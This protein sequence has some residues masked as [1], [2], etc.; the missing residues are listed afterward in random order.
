MKINE[1]KKIDTTISFKTMN[2]LRILTEKKEERLNLQLPCDK[3][4]CLS[5]SGG[6]KNTYVKE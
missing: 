3:R 6:L 1:G 4:A 2:V 5:W